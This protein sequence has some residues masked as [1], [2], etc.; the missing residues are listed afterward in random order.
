MQNFY[1]HGKLLLT[2][3]YVVLDGAKALALPC[4]LGQSL[5]VKSI[6]DQNNQ[7]IS[8]LKNGQVWKSLDFSL[9]EILENKASDKFKTRLF[10]ILKIIYQ[11]KPEL[12]E[13]T[14]AF[15]TQLEFD[16]DWGL[17]SSSTLINNLAQWSKIDPYFLL[18]K[19]FGGSGYDIAAA[20]QKNP[21]IYQRL[22]GKV[23]IQTVEIS[24]RLKPYIYFIYLNQKQNSREAILNYR[25][26]SK[27]E[28]GQNISKVSD[29]TQSI[30]HSSDLKEFENNLKIHEELISKIIDQ[31][32]IQELKFKDYRSGIVKSLGAW[33]GDFVLVTAQN[34]DDLEYFRQKGYEVVY[35]YG[36]LV[37]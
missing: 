3:E 1:S 21:F 4:K 7:W 37:Y 22:D 36:D 31:P 32:P 23:T 24:N 8:Y 13:K 5:S 20:Q 14:Y 9:K 35:N 26:H 27:S 17:G 10:Q 25:K 18:E 33:G 28:K 29:L 6:S 15:S 12:F 30:I 19:T 11:E 34:K 16:K 2:G